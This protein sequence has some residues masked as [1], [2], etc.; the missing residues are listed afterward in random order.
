M[1][2][3]S[4]HLKDLGYLF[5]EVGEAILYKYSPRAFSVIDCFVMNVKQPCR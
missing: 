4:F 5:V 2:N 3:S 1:L